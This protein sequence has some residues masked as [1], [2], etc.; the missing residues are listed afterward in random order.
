MKKAIIALTLAF[1][2]PICGQVAVDPGDLIIFDIYDSYSLVHVG[3]RPN[4]DLLCNLV[5]LV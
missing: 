4:I 2:S 1:N 5:N 3:Y